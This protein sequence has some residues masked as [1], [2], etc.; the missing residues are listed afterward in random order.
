LAGFSYLHEAMKVVEFRKI[1][2]GAMMEALRFLK[3]KKVV[4]CEF[5][6]WYAD[7][8]LK[9]FSC[10]LL[11]DPIFRVAREPLRKLELNGRL[12]GVAQDCL[13]AGFPP[14]NILTGIIS[15]LLFENKQDQD[16]QLSF[17]RKALPPDLLLT[18]V[19]G[20]RRGEALEILIR[21]NFAR[22]ASELK[23]LA[24]RIKKG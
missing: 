23:D 16:Y 6:R 3:F 21:N 14:K 7:R 8:E 11:Y 18:Y 22:I 19:L 10:Q 17:M 20:L 2:E 12:I 5:L 4:P 9:R 13:A 24:K 1:T 15:A